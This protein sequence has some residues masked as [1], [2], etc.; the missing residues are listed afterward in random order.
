[1]RRRW[2]S[3]LGA[4]LVLGWPAAATGG[5]VGD[6]ATLIAAAR[7]QPIPVYGRPGR[8]QPV[9]VFRATTPLGAPRVFLVRAWR[10]RWLRVLLPARPNGSSGWIRLDS[11]SLEETDYL[12]TVDLGR[13]V[14][15]LTQGGTVVLRVPVG[16][17]TAATPTPTGE[18]YVT[19]LVAV[20]PQLQGSY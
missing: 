14:L 16:V 6:R 12:V 19:D 13:H 8:A 4:V 10:G 7:A 5:A 15:T 20:P 9:R 1:M 3:V 11:V 17:G 18:F 2:V